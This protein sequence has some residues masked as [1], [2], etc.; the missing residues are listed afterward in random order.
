VQPADIAVALRRRSPWE[1]MDLGL[2]MLQVWWRQA[3]APHLIVGGLVAALAWTAGWALERPWV[4]FA[5]LWWLKPLYDRVVLHVLSRAVF[6]EVQPLRAV[7]REARHWLGTGL[8]WALTFGRFDFAR[9]FNLPVR[10]LEG[11]RSGAGRARRSLLGRRVSGYAIWLTVVCLHFEAVLYWSFGSLATIFLP[12]TASE[13]KDLIEV[14]F[15]TNVLASGWFA[16]YAAAVL[17]LEP[18]YVAA[19]FAL[20]LNRRTLLEGWDIEV[21]LRRIAQRYAAAA[22]AAAGV[23]ALALGCVLLFPPAAQAAPAPQKDARKE[24]AEVLKGPEFPHYRENM[25]WQLRSKAK[26]ESRA[27]GG[28]SRT[29]DGLFSL[30]V[31]FARVVQVL[32]WIAVAAGVV[33]ILWW[34]VRM[35]PR[36]RAPQ[37]EPYR[38]PAAL[39]GMEIAP[40]KLPD[41]VGAAAARLAAE[42]KLREALG[43]LYRGALSDLVHRRGVE[44]L[45]SHTEAEA[46]HVSLD[47]LPADGGSYLTHLVLAWRQCAY[48][49]REPAGVDVAQL[50]QGFRAF[51]TA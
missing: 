4:A 34:V 2:A 13:G 46:L 9:S 30:G 19:G 43:L 49:R 28:D 25:T 16:A 45:A 27:E 14:L 26:N 47:K 3:Y 12:A 6:G 20:Y 15:S 23:V 10:Q 44:L 51:A 38:P 29:K 36:V 40:E 37:A 50:A 32:F 1:A 22:A 11:Q 21:A 48:A 24:I 42:G 17:F 8:F 41:D 31:G 18:F 7:L 33:Y 35:L 39:F 5:G